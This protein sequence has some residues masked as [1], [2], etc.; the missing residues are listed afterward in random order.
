MM[1]TLLL[2]LAENTYITYNH[3]TDNNQ[4][5]SAIINEEKQVI[6][7]DSRSKVKDYKIVDIVLF[8]FER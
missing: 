5:F 8:L 1:M 3:G 2:E 7:V 4:I 6:S